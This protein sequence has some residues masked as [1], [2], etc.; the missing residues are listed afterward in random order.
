MLT[1]RKKA[2][3]AVTPSLLTLNISYSVQVTQNKTNLNISLHK[4]HTPLSAFKGT[5]TY[6]SDARQLHLWMTKALGVGVGVGK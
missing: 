2:A 1:C 5:Y 6:K 4:T 3:G